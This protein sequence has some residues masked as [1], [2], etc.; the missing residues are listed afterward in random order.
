ML[1]LVISA[2]ILFGLLKFLQNIWPPKASGYYDGTMPTEA[3][4]VENIQGI[5]EILEPHLPGSLEETNPV[6]ANSALASRLYNELN[7]K[8]EAGLMDEIDYNLQLH[9]I[10]AFIDISKDLP[11]K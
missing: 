1:F 8:Y 4:R 2:F 10:I 11:A 7:K 5:R 3:Q 9:K 6:V